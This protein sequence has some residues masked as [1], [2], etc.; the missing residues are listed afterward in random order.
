MFLLLSLVV[1][2]QAPRKEIEASEGGSRSTEQ[3]EVVRAGR[4]E[5]DLGRGTSR[6][7]EVG[8]GTVERPQWISRETEEVVDTRSARRR[9]TNGE[10]QVEEEKEPGRLCPWRRTRRTQQ[11]EVDVEKEDTIGTRTIGVS[12]TE[13]LEEMDGDE[14]EEEIDIKTIARTVLKAATTDTS[15]A[16]ITTTA[17]RVPPTDPPNPGT[18]TLTPPP[19]AGG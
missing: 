13:T 19:T 9:E 8:S 6:L 10:E 7:W 1:L 5:N 11:E 14:Q 17:V 12:S 16:R 18:P 2:Q 4:G 15:I 3:E